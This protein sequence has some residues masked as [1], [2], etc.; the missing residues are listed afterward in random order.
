MIEAVNG[1]DTPSA[2]GVMTRCES[3]KALVTNKLDCGIS[4]INRD[5]VGAVVE[6]QPSA[7]TAYP[8]TASRLARKGTS[9][10]SSRTCEDTTAAGGNVELMR[11]T[12]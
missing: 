6:S 9:S 8:A 10:N 12:T 7:G 5:V 2:G 3:T 11:T 4:Y 1:R